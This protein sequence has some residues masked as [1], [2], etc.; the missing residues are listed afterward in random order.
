M[1]ATAAAGCTGGGPS[2]TID[3]EET[4]EPGSFVELNLLMNASAELTY[5]WT[6][7]PE[8]ALGFDIHTHEGG[9]VDYRQQAETTSHEGSFTAP[10][11]GTYSLQWHN[12]SDEPVTVEM[13]LEGAF[14]LEST[15]P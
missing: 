10:S 13:H 12:P 14:T 4:V 11:Q 15:A 5:R 3:R 1:L 9:E 7:T 6:T 2:T 8:T